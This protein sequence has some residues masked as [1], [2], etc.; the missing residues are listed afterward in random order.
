MSKPMRFLLIASL[1]LNLLVAGVVVGGLV[2][3]GGDGP[4]GGNSVDRG[5]R[6]IGN[7]PFVMALDPEDR[8]ELAQAM[9]LRRDR[10]RENRERLRTRFEAVLDVL[11]A[12]PFEPDALS[13]LLADQRATLFERQQLGEDLLIG[14]L[15]DMTVEQR[16]AY[17]DRVDRS[18]RRGPRKAPRD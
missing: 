11:R 9:G 4:R 3:K 12:D 8:K 10:L 15:K 17:A 1:A 6:D 5:L 7:V 16:A 2:S 18:L 13:T 14:R